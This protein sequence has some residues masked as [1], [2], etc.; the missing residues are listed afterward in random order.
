MPYL[1]LW[2]LPTIFTLHHAQ[3][4]Q[5]AHL[6]ELFQEIREE[7]YPCEKK[8][9]D[10][11]KCHYAFWSNPFIFSCQEA[12][13]QQGCHYLCPSFL[14]QKMILSVLWGTVLLGLLP[15]PL[16]RHSPPVAGGCKVIYQSGPKSQRG[17]WWFSTCCRHLWGQGGGCSFPSAWD[18]SALLEG[19]KAWRQGWLWEQLF[20]FNQEEVF[21]EPNPNANTL[22]SSQDSALPSPISPHC[23]SLRILSKQDPSSV[24]FCCSISSFCGVRA[25]FLPSHH[26][27]PEE[28]LWSWHHQY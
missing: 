6:G 3:G 14:P 16:V 22:L 28:I 2:C 26:L 12:I 5:G 8:G 7:K 25:P 21:S 10:F 17:W 18:S 13:E 9:I 4:V 11:Q 24:T 20:T 1:T 15:C 23:L 27:C 19:S